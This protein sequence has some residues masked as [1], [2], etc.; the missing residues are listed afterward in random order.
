MKEI[1]QI[2]FKKR[3]YIVKVKSQRK[4]VKIK[5]SNIYS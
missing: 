1:T 5:S 2:C 3:E 4:G